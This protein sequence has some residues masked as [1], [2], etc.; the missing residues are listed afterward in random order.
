MKRVIAFV[1]C[2]VLSGGIAVAATVLA[3]AT[4]PLNRFKYRS[5]TIF[6][7]DWLHGLFGQGF[8]LNGGGVESGR[9]SGSRRDDTGDYYMSYGYSLEPHEGPISAGDVLP[10]IVAFYRQK[11]NRP[12]KWF[13]PASGVCI[14]YY[15]NN[16]LNGIIRIY[17]SQVNDS[18]VEVLTEC[19]ENA[20]VPQC[21]PYR[22]AGE[23]RGI[24]RRSPLI[25]RGASPGTLGWS[26]CGPKWRSNS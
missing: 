19:E 22:R 8:S 9:G 18:K 12:I 10:K 23:G 3:T 7:A 16:G 13:R 1:V 15:E 11:S 24:V 2:A 5:N 6:K 21:R 14:G 26:I 20:H 17:V 4:N 25:S